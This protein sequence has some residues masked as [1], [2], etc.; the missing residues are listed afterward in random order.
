LIQI[1]DNLRFA[2]PI[3]PKVKRRLPTPSKLFILPGASGDAA[4][5]A[6]LPCRAHP[7]S[8]QGLGITLKLLI[9]M[10]LFRDGLH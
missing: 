2:F 3:S 4:I 8:R 6:S 5:P 10:S 1:G 7:A 9:M